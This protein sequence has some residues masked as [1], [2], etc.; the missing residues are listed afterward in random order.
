MIN[1]ELKTDIEPTLATRRISFA[2]LQLIQTL[3]DNVFVLRPDDEPP[4]QPQTQELA[5]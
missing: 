3:P 4:E 5:A 2:H 1:H